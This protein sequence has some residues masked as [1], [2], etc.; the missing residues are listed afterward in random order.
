MPSSALTS[1]DQATIDSIVQRMV[2]DVSYR[3]LYLAYRS[4]NWQICGN[5]RPV[6]SAGQ[7]QTHNSS[8]SR[9]RRPS[10][11]CHCFHTFCSCSM[12]CCSRV[13][14]I[15]QAQ[16]TD[17]SSAAKL[18]VIKLPCRY[19]PAAS[20]CLVSTMVFLPVRG[21]LLDLAMTITLVPLCSHMIVYRL[22]L[23]VKTCPGQKSL[24]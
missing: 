2:E 23:S 11:Y 9:V 17:A 19:A 22:D 14:S 6:G 15:H 4:F 13:L 10:R 5:S 1:E 20:V 21:A 16:S 18:H 24:C 3:C 7:L 12:L 8:L